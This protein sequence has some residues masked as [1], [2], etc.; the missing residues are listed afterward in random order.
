[1]EVKKVFK[2]SNFKLLSSKAGITTKI[3]S[4]AI[5]AL[6]VLVVLF[7]VYAQIIP[8]AQGA[9]DSLGDSARCSAAGGFFNESQSACLNGTN[10]ADTAGVTFSTIPLSGLFVGTGVVFVIVI[11]A[12]VVLVVKSL[13]TQR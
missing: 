13:L 8:E 9:G 6:I 12:L 2:K 7:N 3:I 5:L 4:S 1:M 11:A 10:P